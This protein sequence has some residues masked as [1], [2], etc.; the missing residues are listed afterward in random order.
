MA[1]FI[2][3]KNIELV[4]LNTFSIKILY[5]EK[6]LTISD[7]PNTI[8]PIQKVRYFVFDKWIVFWLTCTAKYIDKLI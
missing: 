1:T 7:A 5:F 2:M 6:S 3:N 8:D 4:G